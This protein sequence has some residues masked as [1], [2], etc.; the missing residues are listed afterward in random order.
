MALPASIDLD[1]LYDVTM[2]AAPIF[3]RYGACAFNL[4]LGPFPG[5]LSGQ[6]ILDFADRLLEACVQVIRADRTR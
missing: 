6:A 3:D 4:C 2:I 5:L 1:A